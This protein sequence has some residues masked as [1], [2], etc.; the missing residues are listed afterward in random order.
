MEWL[1]L[2]LLSTIDSKTIDTVILLNDIN[3]VGLDSHTDTGNNRY[4][5]NN[6][7]NEM[8]KE[9]YDL[10]ISKPQLNYKSSNSLKLEQSLNFHNTYVN[11]NSN[12]YQI[13]NVFLHTMFSSLKH[14]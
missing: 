2:R 12:C 14:C 13:S 5:A 8:Y 9:H 7:T 6:F 10:N 1:T 11:H 4:K 3:A